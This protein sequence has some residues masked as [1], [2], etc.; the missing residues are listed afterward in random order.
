MT[1]VELTDR[2]N[3]TCPICYANSGAE[4]LDSHQQPRRHRSLAEIERM[5]DAIVTNE[6]EPQ[7]VQLSGGEPTLH[8]DF[9]AV[10]D[11]V[12]ARPIKHLMINTNGLK[13]AQDRAFGDRLS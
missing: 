3:L 4:K 1:L 2:C 12:K 8:P 6:G 9:F 13:I 11:Q 10:M 5:L 7:V